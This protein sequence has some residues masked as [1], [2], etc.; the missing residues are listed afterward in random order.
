MKE[1]KIFI[2]LP[3]KESLNPKTAGAVSIYV[4]DA[5]KY[6]KYIKKIKIISSD[7]IKLKI[8]RNKIIF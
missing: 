8:F 2:I 6:S 4:R 1:N 5:L 3:F 7:K